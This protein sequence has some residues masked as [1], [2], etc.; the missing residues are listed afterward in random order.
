MQKIIL[1]L[2]FVFS[3]SVFSET[4]KINDDHSE[5]SFKIPYL[6]ITE[7]NGRFTKFQ[8]EAEVIND[9]VRS[10]KIRIETKSIFTGNNIRDGHLRS[11]EF[12]KV[13]EFPFITFQS[14]SVKPQG[15][16]KFLVN[17]TLTIK[18]QSRPHQFKFELS[19]IVDDTWSFKNRFAK[20]KGMIK[21]HDF[22]INWD[23]SLKDNQYL[24]GEEI[25]INGQFQ[26]QPLN[27]LTPTHKFMIPDTQF[28]RV[29]DRINRGE[30]VQIG[31]TN[32]VI[33]ESSL[34]SK[35]PISEKEPE[36][37]V[38]QYQIPSLANLEF[39]RNL[40][41]WIAFLVLGLFGFVAA[42]GGSYWIKYKMSLSTNNEYSEEKSLGIIS[43][44]LAIG[45]ITVYAI[46]FWYVGWNV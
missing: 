42:I 17:G 46:A 34:K 6:K 1:L 14:S 43:D 10:L 25:V 9:E 40:T 22:G 39:N 44:L 20:F 12:L 13:N 15:P 8:G 29:K 45:L 18:D 7:V 37:K 31:Q 30:E 3:S 28:T 24:I 11:A 19:K 16:G 5:I 21:R 26:I 35:D 38:K 33:H 23:K 36:E 41:W 2:L 32:P 4:W 27:S